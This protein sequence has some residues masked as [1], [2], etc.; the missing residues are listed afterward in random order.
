[1]DAWKVGE[2]IAGLLQGGGYP[3]VPASAIL[4]GDLVTTGNEMGR[5]GE[6][7]ESAILEADLAFL[8]REKV[9]F[10]EVATFPLTSLTTAPSEKRGL[11]P[12]PAG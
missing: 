12:Y 2:R 6:L 10:E 7:A 9:S 3:G 4:N 5:P 1:M 8:I 11:I